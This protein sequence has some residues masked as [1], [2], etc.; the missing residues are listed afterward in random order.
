MGLEF[1][2]GVRIVLIMFTRA[3]TNPFLLVRTSGF[4]W[5]AP[6][7]S[8]YFLTIRYSSH[9]Y[10]P[11][12]NASSS[13]WWIKSQT[14]SHFRNTAH[15]GDSSR[16]T[17]SPPCLLSFFFFLFNVSIPRRG[18][19]CDCLEP[20]RRVICCAVIYI[21]HSTP[22]CSFSACSVLFVPTN[23]LMF[24]YSCGTVGY[25]CLFSKMILLNRASY[26]LNSSASHWSPHR[27]GIPLVN[28]NL[29]L[30][31]LLSCWW[32]FL[33]KYRIPFRVQALFHVCCDFPQSC[34][35]NFSAIELISSSASIDLLAYP[36]E[37]LISPVNPDAHR[38][39]WSI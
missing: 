7:S 17:A 2:L 36:W 32:L 29:N 16:F 28:V 21:K 3:H 4:L 38:F 20:T 13:T 22:F 18:E 26:C 25:P 5:M 12:R 8:S 35:C 24:M 11:L 39:P 27:Y 30:A 33:D 15:K 10:P 14:W 19:I 37:S 1:S 6:H 34:S 9:L 23:D 31:F